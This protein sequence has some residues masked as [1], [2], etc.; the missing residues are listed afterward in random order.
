[1]RERGKTEITKAE[2]LNSGTT[3]L[4]GRRLGR[5]TRSENSAVLPNLFELQFSAFAISAFQLSA[6]SFE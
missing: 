1:M 3:G 5:P 4:P 6:F 2:T